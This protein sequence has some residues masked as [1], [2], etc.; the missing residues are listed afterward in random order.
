MLLAIVSELYVRGTVVKQTMKHIPGLV[1]N[2]ML[3]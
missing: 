2:L 1:H 3:L